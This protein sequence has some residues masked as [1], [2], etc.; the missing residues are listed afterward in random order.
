MVHSI[1]FVVD[2]ISDD[3]IQARKL[4]AKGVAEHVTVLVDPQAL[5]QLH[6]QKGETR[7]LNVVP[8]GPHNYQYEPDVILDSSMTV[9][10][11]SGAQVTLDFMNSR[12]N[13]EAVSAQPS[14]ALAGELRDKMATAGHYFGLRYSS[15]KACFE[16][17]GNHYVVKSRVVVARLLNVA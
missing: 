11:S 6:L 13:W 14:A 17:V 3:R 12:A 5:A 16:P 10:L 15:S 2:A 9:R 4:V 1:S 7:S 8:L